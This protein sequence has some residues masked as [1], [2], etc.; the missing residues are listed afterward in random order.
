MRD[1]DFSEWFA[2]KSFS[3]DWTSRFFPI[4][5]FLLAPRRHE[6]LEVL[7]IG[8]WEG[9]SA[10]FFLQY[11]KK[12]RITCID[13]FGGS[14][15]HALRP[16]WASALPHIEK[17]FDSNLA[18]FGVRVEKIKST[19]SRGLARLLTEERRFDLVYIDG[20]HHSADVQ[21][22][23]VS[24]WPMILDRGVVIFDD[25]EWTFFAR[26]IDR[27]KLGIDTFLSAHTNQYR[28]L[29][30]GYQLI[31]EKIGHLRTEHSQGPRSCGRT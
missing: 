20:C 11:L 28:E 15:E 19:S 25:Y 23:A 18:D 4:W 16:N 31:I 7:E 29:H 12:C 21:A 10:I 26:E 14:P 17:R 30:R 2:G 22:D 9:R 5:A 1:T 13:T 27:P 24:S 3:T 6:A 8:S